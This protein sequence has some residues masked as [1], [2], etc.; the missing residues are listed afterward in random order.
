MMFKPTLVLAA[1]CGTAIA[2]EVHG[3]VTFEVQWT[4]TTSPLDKAIKDN[5]ESS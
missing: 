2:A 4:N 1:I 5:Y 3:G